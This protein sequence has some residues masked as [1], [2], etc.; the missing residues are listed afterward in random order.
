MDYNLDVGFANFKRNNPNMDNSHARLLIAI[1]LNAIHDAVAAT[2]TVSEKRQAWEWLERDDIMLD[3]C[4]T[5][6]GIEKEGLL[7]RVRFMRDNN[8]N[9]K[10]MYT[11][12]TSI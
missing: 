11:K 1:L 3:Y 10:N 7:R 5:V 4:L 12:R 2:A 9:L 8:I 6:A